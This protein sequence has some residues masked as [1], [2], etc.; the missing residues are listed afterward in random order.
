MRPAVSWALLSCVLLGCSSDR[1]AI[2]R[3]LAELQEDIRKLH[4]KD[5]SIAGRL[6]SLESKAIRAAAPEPANGSRV[7]RPELKVIKVVPGE[8]AA[9]GAALDGEVAP[10]ERPDA[11]GSRPVIRL[12]GKEGRASDNA[13]IVARQSGEDR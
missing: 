8:T 7:V 9:D 2:D 10:E 11:P 4:A 13:D 6:E 12:R 1:D 3:R 5:D